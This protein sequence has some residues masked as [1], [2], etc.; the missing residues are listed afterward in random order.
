MRWKHNLLLL[1]K[2]SCFK[3]NVLNW[4]IFSVS[5]IV[6]GGIDC[7]LVHCIIETRK[8]N[9]YPPIPH[10]S[11]ISFSADSELL[12]LQYESYLELWRLGEADQVR[13]FIL[14]L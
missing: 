3:I 6:S 5:D 11:L 8:V 12:L 10:A 9:V 7:N 14:F 2:F 1:Y 4:M 13:I